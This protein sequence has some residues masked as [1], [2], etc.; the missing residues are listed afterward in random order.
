MCFDVKAEG[1]HTLC[2][3]HFAWRGYPLQQ[4]GGV[5]ISESVSP[6]S[7]TVP[8]IKGPV[9]A[10]IACDPCKGIKRCT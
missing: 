8:L 9:N 2:P 3:Y 1:G 6:E 7:M 4:G 10:V 5:N